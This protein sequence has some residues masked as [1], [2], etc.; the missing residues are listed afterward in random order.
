[1]PERARLAAL[2]EYEILDTPAEPAFDDVVRLAADVF[3]APIALVTLVADGRQWFKAE[4]G[5]GIRETPLQDSICLHGMHA[6]EVMV[7]PDTRDDPR[8]SGGALVAAPD[9]VRFYAGAPL[10][11]PEGVAIGMVCV[12]DRKPRPEGVTPLQ[13]LTLQVL[14]RQVMSELELRRMVRAQAARTQALQQEVLER[15]AASRA[16]A[17]SQLRY[18]SLFDSLDAGFCILDLAFDADGRARDYRYV[19]VNPAFAEQTGLHDVQGRWMRDLAPDHEQHWFDT[20]GRVAITGQPARFENVAAALGRWYDVHAFRVGPPEARRVAVLFNDITARR[21]AEVDLRELN[22]TLDVRVA[23]TLAG[24]LEAEEALRQ[25][26]KMEAIGQLT[27]GVAHDFNNLLT[28]IRGSVELLRR[29]DLP[30]E[31]RDRYLDAVADTAERAGRLTGQLLAFARRQALKPEVF[32]V[33]A[34]VQGVS[35]VVA[36]LTGSRISV[37]TYLADDACFVCADRSQFDTAIVNMAVNARDAMQGEGRISIAV[38][39]VSGVPAVRNHPPVCG[40]FVAVAIT[41]NG[42]GI[43]PDAVA[44]I[45]EPFYTTKAVG[46]GTGLGLSQVIGFAKQS[47]GEIRVDSK[48]GDG[49]TFTLY[50]PRVRP[51]AAPATVDDAPAERRDAGGGVCVLLVED[52][53]QVGDFAVQALGEL[54]YDSVLASDADQALAKLEADHSRFQVVFSDVVMP[55]MNGMEL[56]RRVRELYPHLPVVLTSG[57]SHVLA[58]NG[59][60]GFELLHKPY[61]VEQ[62]SRVL[63]KA[64]AWHERQRQAAAPQGP[65][66]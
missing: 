32:D 28:V 29:P 59:H 33:G 64:I 22:Q 21:R 55:G 63:A 60:Q 57:Y 50:M 51:D 49:S 12:I 38:G 23:E 5:F 20:Y 15:E 25:A 48:L 27:G 40:D 66:A 3:A 61:S 62:L 36:S 39:P 10:R 35:E 1:M 46:A 4:L 34:S 54:G 11:T 30:P 13:R 44:R 31:R 53:E 26:Q 6:D 14:A 58:Q 18:Q 37:E 24:R 45:F 7:V 9:G 47:D 65:T 17:E 2:A 19:E 16:L 43:A 41:D 8:L 56:G 52:N 42:E